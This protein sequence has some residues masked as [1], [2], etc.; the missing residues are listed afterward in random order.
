MITTLRPDL[1]QPA[2]KK[3]K[4]DKKAVAPQKPEIYLCTPIPAFKSTWNIND[5]VIANAII[6]IQQEVAKKFG[7]HVIDLHTL[8]ANDGDKML[9]DGI[10][11]DAKGARRL[12]EIIAEAISKK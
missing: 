12:A 1:A 5:S 11:P 7:L 2:K 8:Y 6:P 3:G 9:N 4:K 10:H